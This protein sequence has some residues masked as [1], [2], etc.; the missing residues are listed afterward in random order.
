MKLRISGNTIRLR[1][2]QAEVEQIGRGEPVRQTLTMNEDVNFGYSLA[3]AADSLSISA[4]YTPN[5]LVVFVPSTLAKTWTDTDLVSLRHVQGENTDHEI[6]ILV[7]KDFQ[8]L[9]K[10]P[11]E[12]ESDNY[13]NPKAPQPPSQ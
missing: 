13:P 9:H 1:L 10:R 8:C 3:T 6:L 7:E 5:D 2:T 11:D 4:R 12:D